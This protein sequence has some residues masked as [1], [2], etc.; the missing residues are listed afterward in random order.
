MTPVWLE[1]AWRWHPSDAALHV[2]VVDEGTR[3]IG[4]APLALT[5]RSVGGWAVRTLGWV[6]VPDTQFAD[7]PALTGHSKAVPQAVAELLQRRAA[8]WDLLEL[9]HLSDCHDGWRA[10]EQA[11]SDLGINTEVERIGNNPFIDL[12]GSFES[13]Y[14][15]RSRSL[16]K[17]VNLS[18]NRLA[19]A[20]QVS[21]EWIREGQRV[22][23]ALPEVIRVSSLSWKKD[24]GNSLDQPGPRA[25]I[26]TLTNNLQS[27]GQ[28]S[29]W[30]L[31]LDGKVIA[32][33]YQVIADGHVYALRS[34]FDP[35][36]SDM[37]PGTFLNHYLLKRL[38]GS[39]LIRYYMGPGEN[40]YKMRWT[41]HAEPI[42]RLTAYSP[43]ARGQLLRWLNRSARLLARRLR[44]S[45]LRL[46][47]R[48]P[49][50]Q[51]TA[52]IEP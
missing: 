52:N 48:E 5:T 40:A 7:L 38:F 39:D 1:A 50:V 13:Y 10:L 43:T 35:A 30:L 36:Y 4:L 24:T 3:L 6:T 17:A 12:G 51:N 27:T 8:Q 33:E 19:R 32:T 11:L 23:N 21:V 47:P 14:D 49:S 29:I 18:A 45:L 22:Q 31:R 37:S 26:E 16:K 20:G 44:D 28:L 42:Y 25:F 46:R 15:T 2:I 41:D 9:T 34:D